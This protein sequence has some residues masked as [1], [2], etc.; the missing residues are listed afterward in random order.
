MASSRTGEEVLGTAVVEGNLETFGRCLELSGISSVNPNQFLNNCVSVTITKLLA[1]RDVHEFWRETLH[2]DLLDRPLSFKEITLLLSKTGWDFTWKVY[3][4]CSGASAY[5][6]MKQDHW[7]IFADRSPFRALAYT[8]RNGIGHCVVS[9]PLTELLH[10][11]D[12]C[13]GQNFICYQNDTYGVSVQT[14]VLD[15]EKLIVFFLHCPQHTPQWDAWH[16]RRYLRMSERRRDPVWWNRRLEG[17][18]KC[19]EI[20]GVSP[21]LMMPSIQDF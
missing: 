17:V 11:D 3:Q 16:D 19:L 10:D 13:W 8:R 1:Y 21:L 2:G 7:R 15:A 5:L 4:P 14:E 18:N 9:S 20:L 6:N 12:E